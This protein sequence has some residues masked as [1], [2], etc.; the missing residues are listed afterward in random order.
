MITH[1]LKVALRNLVKYRTQ[2]VISVLGLAIGLAFFVFG[3]YWLKYETSYD[4]FY[5]DAGRSYLVYVQ[6]ENNKSGYSPSALADFIR[7]RLPEAEIVTRSYEGGNGNMDYRFDETTVKNPNFMAVDSL[8]IRIF[9]QMMVCG[10]TLEREDEIIVSESFAKQHFRRPEKALGVTLH[11]VAPAGFHLADARQLRIVGVMADAPQNATMTP[12]GYYRQPESRMA[13]I[14]N[15]KEWEYN[16]GLTHVMLREGVKEEDFKAHLEKALG[17]QD[18]LKEKSFK[19]IPLNQKHFEF[20]SEESFSYS[21]ISMFTLATGLLLCCV[22]FNFMNLFLNR[23]YQRVREVKL[24]KAVGASTVKLLLQVMV[25]IMSYVLLGALICGCI[26]ELSLPLFEDIFGIGIPKSNI[27]YLYLY[28]F[29]VA[30]AVIQVLLLLL[31]W[32]FIRSVGRQSLTGRPESSGRNQ[33]RRVGLA[34]QLVICLFFLA[35]ASSLYR[36]LHFM[37]DTDLGFD[38]KHIVE[39]TVR[40]FEQNAKNMLEEI[41]QLPMIERH[42]TAS[43]W[44]VL[45]EG[46]QTNGGY[47]WRGKTEEDKNLSFAPIELTQAADRMFNFRLKEGRTY[48]D[49]D[50]KNTN[51]QKDFLTGNPVLNKVL[52][53]ESAARAIRL[54]HPVGEIIR[55]PIQL[56]G[57]EPVWTDYEII[58]VIRDFHP[59]GLKAEPLPTLVFQNFRFI[60]PINYFQ[61]TPGTES[62]FIKA[63]DN[64]AQK[65][66]WIYEGINTPPQLLSDKMKELNKSETATFQL[67]AVLTFLCILISLFG[68]FAISATTIAQRRKEIAVRKVMGATTHDVVNMFFREY[69]WLVSISAIIAFPFFYWVVSRWL[70]QFA[71]RVNIGIGMYVVLSAITIVL[72]LMTVFRQV[73]MAARENPADVVKSE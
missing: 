65:H 58:G 60:S 37:N 2:S 55:V 31:S 11:Q 67:F 25:E 52:I 1:Y 73:M 19:V 46:F 62:E 15:P 63:V 18:F 45:K 57:R 13:D 23:Y 24:R 20:A 22:L 17:Q 27:M 16:S 39:L 8:F 32:Q 33:V 49:E 10:R 61:V 70:E 71:Y 50:W 14:N 64:L 56:M 12:V 30:L 54:E 3:L 4:N 34:I 28:V 47:E 72:V 68:V 7:E 53:S 51:G 9:P 59:Q 35:S 42:A 44:M 40:S 69:S 43:Q 21:A 41:K 5:P 48:T 66:N 38:T 29:L 36:Q 6:A 26:I